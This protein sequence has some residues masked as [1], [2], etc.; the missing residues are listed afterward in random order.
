MFTVEF[1][2]SLNSL[3]KTDLLACAPRT[4]RFETQPQRAKEGFRQSG[5]SQRKLAASSTTPL[6]AVT[7]R[8]RQR[9]ANYAITHN[10]A[11]TTSHT[12]VL[13]YVHSFYSTP[14]PH[15]R[16]VVSGLRKWRR[17]VASWLLLVTV[18]A[19]RLV[20]SCEC[21]ILSYGDWI[22]CLLTLVIVSSRKAHFQRYAPLP[23]VP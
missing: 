15:Y 4:T 20:C 14:G 16:R 23:N 19:E 1:Q 5:K 18:L 6:K 11:S 7:P 13:R 21:S 22:I 2:T 9:L 8:N 17:S 3:S 10:R 12:L